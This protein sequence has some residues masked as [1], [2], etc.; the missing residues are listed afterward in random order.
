M[1]ISISGIDSFTDMPVNVILSI[2]HMAS[3]APAPSAATS[4]GIVASADFQGFTRNQGFTNDTAG[5]VKNPAVGLSRHLHEVGCRFLVQSFEIAQ[6]NCFQFFDC[7]HHFPGDR[8][9]LGDKSGDGRVTGYKSRFFRS[10][11]VFFI[12]YNGHLT[13]I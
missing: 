13:K 7:Q 5:I 6:S 4:H 2:F 11:H 9:A 1:V 12:S 8:H 3:P 10:R